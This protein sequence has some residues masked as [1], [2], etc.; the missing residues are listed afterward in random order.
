MLDK[1]NG[2]RFTLRLKVVDMDDHYD[3]ESLESN[4]HYKVAVAE[5]SLDPH[6]LRMDGVLKVFRPMDKLVQF[7]KPLLVVGGRG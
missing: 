4:L 6:P 1:D 2:L 5:M 3:E 7:E